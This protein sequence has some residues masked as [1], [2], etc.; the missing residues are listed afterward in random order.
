MSDSKRRDQK[1]RRREKRQTRRDEYK[2][3]I[4]SILRSLQHLTG[5]PEPRSWPGAGRSVA[6]PARPNQVR[7]EHDY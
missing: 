3:S 5:F 1:K 6:E 7:T 4:E 2:S